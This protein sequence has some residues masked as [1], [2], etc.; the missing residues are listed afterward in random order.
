[1]STRRQRERVKLL[2]GCEDDMGRPIHGL[3][4][5]LIDIESLRV[6]MNRA[7]SNN[8]RT[9]TNGALIVNYQAMTEAQAK[10]FIEQERKAGRFQDADGQHPEAAHA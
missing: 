3:F 4:E 7:R 10:F 8:S 9:S 5:V 2:H 6:Q 1:M